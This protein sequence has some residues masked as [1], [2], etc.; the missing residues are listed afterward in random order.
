MSMSYANDARWVQIVKFARWA[1][2]QMWCQI[3]IA[4]QQTEFT[5]PVSRVPY[6]LASGN[7]WANYPWAIKP[8]ADLPSRVHTVTIGCGLGGSA[9]AY[10]WARRAKADQK[11]LILD[12]NDPASGS[13]GRNEG[14]VVMGRYYHLVCKTVRPYIQ[15]VRSDLNSSEQESIVRQFAAAYASACYRNADLIEQ[16]ILHE[17]F[18][19]DYAREGWVQARD[20]QE[21][22]QLAE[23]V[24]MALDSGFTDWTSIEPDEVLHRTGMT[25]RHNAGFSLAAASFHPAKWCWSL[26]AYAIDSQKVDLFTRTKVTQVEDAG[27]TYLVHTLR[28]PVRA[29]HVVVATESYT[30]LLYPQFHDLIRPIQTQAATGD[31][32]PLQMKPHVGISTSSGFFGRH[33]GKTMVGSDAT[34]VPDHEAGRIQP[35]RFLTKYVCAEMNNHFGPSDYRITN[36]WSGTVSFTPDEYPIVGAFDAKCQYIL[37]GMAGSGTAVSFNGGRC[38]VNRILGLTDEPDDYPPQ[39]FAPSRLLDPHNHPWPDPST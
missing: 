37:G 28:G 13:G 3:P 11:M 9:L 30:P 38:L 7:P 34:R 5:K 23:S 19:C 21:Q 39:C 27:E 18:D 16:T 26:L 12:M 17:G 22:Q 31:G 15:Q 10:H 36:E 29:D 32:G 24:Q 33:H 1:L 35:S 4:M 20:G 14:L 6:W 8:N 25:V 2:R